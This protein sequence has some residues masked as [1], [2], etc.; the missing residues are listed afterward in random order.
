LTVKAKGNTLEN[1]STTAEV[2]KAPSA[3]RLS[4]RP[5]LGG[6]RA[7][8]QSPLYAVERGRF[9]RGPF[10]AYFAGCLVSLVFP[11]VALVTFWREPALQ[12]GS[13]ALWL[14]LVFTPASV[15]IEGVLSARHNGMLDSLILSPVPR[16][17]LLWA[18]LLARLR[19]F[20]WLA[21]ASPLIGAL[22]GGLLGGL[23]GALASEEVLE[24]SQLS[25]FFAAAVPALVWGLVAGLGAGGF[26]AAQSL[27]GGTLGLYFALRTGGRM[28]SRLLAAAALVAI[29]GAAALAGFLLWALMVPAIHVLPRELSALCN[30]VVCGLLFLALLGTV[31]LLLPDGLMLHAACQ[32]D[33]WLLHEPKVRMSGDP[34]ARSPRAKRKGE[35]A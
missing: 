16:G 3:K 35:P 21:A 10:L 20:F 29:Q 25:E 5:F 18:M 14:V 26:I 4:R 11:F 2:G 9:G 1:M 17:R 8:L 6:I 32:S 24:Y 23:L 12:Y 33:R 28:L 27:L 13:T 31:Y 22:I 30:M 15:A 34:Q 19:P 7:T